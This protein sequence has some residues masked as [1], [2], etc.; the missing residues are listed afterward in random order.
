[1]TTASARRLKRLEAASQPKALGHYHCVYARDM[2]DYERQRADL[3]ASGRVK[4]GEL[5]IDA[6]WQTSRQRGGDPL[7]APVYLDDMREPETHAWTM[8]WAE[9]IRERESEK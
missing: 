1:M 2:A 6:N 3:I 4:A 9:F 7:E 8:T 5:I